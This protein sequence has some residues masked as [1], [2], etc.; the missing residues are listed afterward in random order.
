ML[1]E[2]GADFVDVLD[3]DGPDHRR[4]PDAA[5]RRARGAARLTRTGWLFRCLY[6]VYL[7]IKTNRSPGFG[8]VP[9]GGKMDDSVPD[10]RGD[11]G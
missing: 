6:F 3:P 5:P 4:L 9:P 7:D 10:P 8:R 11:D 2:I 1:R